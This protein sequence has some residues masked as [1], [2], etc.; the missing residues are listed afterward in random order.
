MTHILCWRRSGQSC[1]FLIFTQNY[2]SLLCQF[3]EQSIKWH[4]ELGRGG[5]REPPAVTLAFRCGRSTDCKLRSAFLCIR[6]AR[7]RAYS[8]NMHSSRVINSRGL[9][10]D[11]AVSGSGQLSVPLSVTGRER[12][13]DT[14]SSTLR[15]S[16]AGYLLLLKCFGTS[17]FVLYIT[18][19]MKITPWYETDI[20]FV[21]CWCLGFH[22]TFQRTTFQA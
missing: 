16:T 5:K 9:K 11:G 17:Y 12:Q 3:A 4:I 21:R 18:D 22:T 15:N 8:I 1:A 2:P 14:Y 19:G 13:T 20:L 10:R 6:D 7:Y